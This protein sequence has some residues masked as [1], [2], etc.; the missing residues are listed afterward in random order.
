M[1]K[2]SEFAVLHLPGKGH[3]NYY[4]LTNYLPVNCQ[5]LRKWHCREGHRTKNV[6]I[7]TE[8]QF[9]AVLCHIP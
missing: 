7:I 1:K 3:Q 5:L 9:L 6:E 8:I 4:Q 2:L